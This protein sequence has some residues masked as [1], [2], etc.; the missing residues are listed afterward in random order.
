MELMGTISAKP[1]VSANSDMWAAVR[2]QQHGTQKIWNVK[3]TWPWPVK[4][5][6][7]K[8]TE[9]VVTLRPDPLPDTGFGLQYQLATAKL[10]LKGVAVHPHLDTLA[11]VGITPAVAKL[12]CDHFGAA[13]VSRL[14][15]MQRVDDFSGLGAIRGMTPARVDS[16]RRSKLSLI[17]AAECVARS[18]PGLAPSEKKRMTGFHSDVA[19]LQSNPFVCWSSGILSFE[20]ARALCK[21]T[22]AAWEVAH[23]LH[24]L[25]T[26]V[27]AT[28]DVCMHAP[29]LADA[30]SRMGCVL[31]AARVLA[32]ALSGE[33]LVCLSSGAAAADDDGSDDDEEDGGEDLVPVSTL[34]SMCVDG[35]YIYLRGAYDSETEIVQYITASAA[36]ATAAP[37][38]EWARAAE[39]VR[40]QLSAHSL[41]ATQ[42]SAAT[43]MVMSPVSILTGGAGTGKTHILRAVNALFK[44]AWPGGQVLFLA[45]TGCAALRIQTLMNQEVMAF[46]MHS[47]MYRETLPVSAGRHVLAVV[48]EASMADVHIFG[49]VLKMA[50]RQGWRLACVGDVNQ[51][52]PVGMGAPFKALLELARHGNIP[53]TVL[54]RNYRTEESGEAV[55]AAAANVLAGVVPAAASID[56][57]FRVLETTAADVVAAVLS[58]VDRL[59][60]THSMHS[61]SLPQVLAHTNAMCNELNVRIREKFFPA[62]ASGAAAA[63]PTK[64]TPSFDW[65]WAV[66]DLVVMTKNRYVSVGAGGSV[67]RVMVAANGT[68]GEVSRVQL[69]GGAGSSVAAVTVRLEN[70]PSDQHQVLEYVLRPQ[71]VQGEKRAA[72]KLQSLR[73]AY[74]ITVHKAQGG[75][76]P[77]VVYAARGQFGRERKYVYTGMTRAR[78]YCSV[79]TTPGYMEVAVL[80]DEADRVDRICARCL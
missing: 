53:C 22:D 24:A 72:G 78:A 2:I 27:K 33:S 1:N 4:T 40:E 31:S 62:A 5:A 66:G 56:G 67:K 20:R 6:L 8:G 26:H 60:L 52:P 21:P 14:C 45:P 44:N 41:D 13:V 54:Q 64:L 7:E 71:K 43:N 70:P 16:V 50:H 57:R 18:F 46:T 37:D 59:R 12:L 76:F 42:A 9:V 68:R 38:P 15:D 36:A 63:A 74:A 34:F 39:T 49:A 51:L 28:G 11:Q 23:V 17:S 61:H 47:L 80:H 75:E 25:R 73:P 58:E 3:G 35:E 77:C 10:L 65:Q 48:D 55:S 19:V 79:V 30:V 69:F 29:L 32:L